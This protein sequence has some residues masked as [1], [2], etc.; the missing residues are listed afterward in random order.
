MPR[1]GFQVLREHSCRHLVNSGQRLPSE[2]LKFSINAVQD[3]LPHN[4]NL[5][6]WRKNEC[7]SPFCKLCGEKQTLI[8]VLNSCPKALSLCC[9]NEGHDAVLDGLANVFARSLPEENKH[10]ADLPNP[11]PYLVP[12]HI[13]Q[14]D[15]RPDLEI[16]TN[17]AREVW[18]IERFETSYEEAHRRKTTHYA[19]LIEQITSSK[20]DGKLV[21]LEVGSRGFL[22]LP[23]FTTLQQQLLECFKKQWR[24]YLKMLP[25]QPSKV[26]MCN[27]ELV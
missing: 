15:E 12:S 25:R 11:K 3:T 23:T 8:H 5:A 7:L 21:T 4:V 13:A 10:N 16:Q 22:S 26:C 6:R 9:Y 24:E 17:S 14:T 27:A 18:V 20:F 1:P 19:D 2:L